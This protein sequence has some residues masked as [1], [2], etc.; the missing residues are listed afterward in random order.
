MVKV[1]VRVRPL[2]QEEEGQGH[3]CQD[4][5]VV[6]DCSE[7]ESSIITT[8]L[9]LKGKRFGGLATVLSIGADNQVTYLDAVQPL[10]PHVLDGKTVCCFCYGHTNSGKTH[11]II[12]YG[13]ELGMYQHAAKELF[14][15]I[16]NQRSTR[17]HASTG[18]ETIDQSF[19]LLIQVRFAEL[20]NGRVYDLLDGHK[21]CHVREDGDSNIHIRSATQIGPQGQVLVQSLLAKYAEDF[22]TLQDIITTAMRLRATGTSELHDQSSRSHAI[23]ELELV[24]PHLARCRQRLVTAESEIVPVGKSRDG[25]YI[26]MQSK[27]YSKCPKTGGYIH[28]PNGASLEEH[29]TFEQLNAE[30]AALQGV[31]DAAKS[32][33]GKAITTAGNTMVGGKFVF[34][35]LAGAEFTGE[36]NFRTPTER[37]EAREINSSLLALKE[38]IRAQHSQRT[39]IPYRNSKLTMILKAYLES[40]GASTVMIA[41]VSSSVAHISKTINTLQYASLVANAT[42]I[43]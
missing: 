7:A 38:C 26:S 22:E 5:L 3:E 30:V 31:I 2:S 12:G 19:K 25:A 11:T 17:R 18:D 10:I 16:K 42:A 41:N 34:V 6:N 4:F 15:S 9:V 29:E 32:E 39:H 1:H 27:C 24:T 14:D 21:E 43:G 13:K 36:G 37:K 20:Y 8:A 33:V 40:Q 35:D 23:L 28:N